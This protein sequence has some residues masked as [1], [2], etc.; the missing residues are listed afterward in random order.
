MEEG[1][2]VIDMRNNYECLIGHFEGAYLPKA[3]NFRGAIEE[4]RK[5]LSALRTCKGEGG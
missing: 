4:V 1:A 3:D 2:L 5:C